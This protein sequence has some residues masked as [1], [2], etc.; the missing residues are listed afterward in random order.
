M[1]ENYSCTKC[2]AHPGDE[3]EVFYGCGACGNKLFRLKEEFRPIQ[4]VS[5]PTCDNQSKSR[6]DIS[7]IEVEGTG[8]YHLNV[9]KLFQNNTKSKI[10]PLL[11]SDEEGIY[12]IKL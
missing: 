9:D 12:H 11:V 7:S 8:V 5:S 1:L 3:K 10:S 4:A 6:D 2:G